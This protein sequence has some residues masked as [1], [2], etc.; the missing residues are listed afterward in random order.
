M[1]RVH[2][3]MLLDIIAKI[4]DM[5]GRLGTSLMHLGISEAPTSV[6][7]FKWSWLRKKWESSLRS[8]KKG[9]STT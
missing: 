3:T 8:V 4:L 5:H 1:S 7:T 2:Y 9:L 6:G